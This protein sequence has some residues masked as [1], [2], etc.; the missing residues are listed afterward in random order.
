MIERRDV[1]TSEKKQENALLNP[2]RSIDHNVIHGTST[3]VFTC[4]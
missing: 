1:G 2:G 3:M 4:L